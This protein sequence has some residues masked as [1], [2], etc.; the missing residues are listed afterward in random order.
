MNGTD[1]EVQVHIGIIGGGPAGLSAAIWA[2]RYLH[3]VA[4][5]DS[6]D[7]RNW[8]TRKINGYLGLDA[9]KPADLRASGRDTCRTLGVRLVDAIVI[10]LE[11]PSAEHFVIC[12]E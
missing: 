6:G 8:D 11:Q 5:V 9:V 12:L 4:V 3:S 1:T 2:A 7:P 10:R